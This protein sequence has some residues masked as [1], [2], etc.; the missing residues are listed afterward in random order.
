MKHITFDDLA[1]LSQ[2]L[3]LRCEKC[4]RPGRYDVGRILCAEEGQLPAPQYAFS[5]YFRCS[6]C[7]S[8]GPWE[9]LDRL[10]LQSLTLR[11]LCD[12]GFNGV[13][14]GYC[15]LFD[16]TFIQ[17]VAMGEDHLLSLLLKEPS[18]AFLHTRLGNLFRGCGQR[19][20]AVQWYEKALGLDPGDVEA[21]FHLF[22]FAF[23]DQDVPLAA[24]HARLLVKHFL[25]GRGTNK[26]ELTTGIARYVVDEL[27]DAPEAFHRHFCD[28]P[29]D[30]PEL[31]FIQ[32][33]MG[34]EGNQDE[35]AAEAA[36]RLLQG[37][38]EPTRSFD[39]AEP[40]ALEPAVFAPAASLQ[41]LLKARRWDIEQVKVALLADEQRHIRI[42][43]RHCVALTDGKEV[44]VW[45]VS[46]LGELFRGRRVPPAQMDHFPEEYD[47]HFYLIEQHFLKL[48]DALGDRPDQEI[49]QIYS[50]LRRR[51][52]GKSLGPAHDFMWQ[53]AALLLG[54]HCLSQAEF[55]SIYAAL[56]SSTR[57]WG[58]RPVSRNYAA[59]LRRSLAL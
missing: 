26:P 10:R 37:Q 58:L 18:N 14:G 49:E 59:F 23:E 2:K 20:R 21:R 25:A 39:R 56:E 5:N 41:E 46:S 19:S 38:A 29:S 43:D 55:E 30:A 12:N 16:G 15:A 51:P 7:G 27:L 54:T 36:R 28:S 4:D 1:P 8:S 24:N 57:K 48:C 9:I 35:I 42:Q 3:K 13:M 31:R 6:N 40:E 45:P 11:T 50:L 33:L 34:S 47:P 44:A 53:T 52:E 17:T 22:R 32:T